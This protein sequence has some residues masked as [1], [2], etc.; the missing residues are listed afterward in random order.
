MPLPDVASARQG[1]LHHLAAVSWL[2]AL[3]FCCRQGHRE[4]VPGHLP[5]AER[6]HSEGQ[7]PEGAQV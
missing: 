4:G 2:K 7:D 5:P 6:V 1:R 3:S